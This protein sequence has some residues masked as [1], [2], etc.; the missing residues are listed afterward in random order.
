MIRKNGLPDLRFRVNR[1]KLAGYQSTQR[2][3]YIR[4]FVG[5][6]ILG[7]LAGAI[8]TSILLPKTKPSDVKNEDQPEITNL[9]KEVKAVEPLTWNDA[10]RQVFPADEAGRMIRICLKEHQGWK[11]DPRYA[12]NDKNTNGTFDYGWC[13]VNSCHKPKGMTDSDWKTYLEDPMNHAKEVRRIFLSQWWGAWTV[14]TK[15]LVK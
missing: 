9:I 13:Q 14:F 15:G 7:F 8:L 1:D 11:G 2:Q 12:L 4:L 6:A 3:S 10:I 5:F